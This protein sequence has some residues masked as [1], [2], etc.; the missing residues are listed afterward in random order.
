MINAEPQAFWCNA[1]PIISGW[2][3]VGALRENNR[4]KQRERY[5]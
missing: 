1:I 3:E 4:D 2:V 5:G